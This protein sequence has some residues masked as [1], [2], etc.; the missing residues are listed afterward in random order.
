MVKDWNKTML[1]W[2]SLY[3][4]LL[5]IEVKLKKSRRKDI[6]KYAVIKHVN[7]CIS[8]ISLQIR[9]V[10]IDGANYGYLKREHSYIFL[11]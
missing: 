9:N 8:A 7:D 10:D 5:C 3:K 4:K 11:N 1:T 2:S 6:N